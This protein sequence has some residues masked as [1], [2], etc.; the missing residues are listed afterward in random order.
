[1]KTQITMLL[2]VG[3]IVA[4]A[5]TATADTI[6]FQEGVNGYTHDA[7]TLREHDQ[8]DLNGDAWDNMYLGSYFD[9]HSR[10]LMD[11]DLSSLGAAGMIQIDSITLTVTQYTNADAS[12]NKNITYALYETTT[13]WVSSEATWNNRL[14]PDYD[15]FP[16]V[17]TAWDAG[18][19]T[20]IKTGDTYAG[21]GDY[22][23]EISNFVTN[24]TD[25]DE[26]ET[27]TW[28]STAAF[29]TAAQNAFDDD[30]H[31]ELLAA[32]TNTA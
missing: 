28:G 4:L 24:P 5:G 17:G 1:M 31:L 2:V 8:R 3:M 25:L 7:T 6:T 30:G 10:A 15:N 11:F 22:G 13:D 29:V 12:I 32:D 23:P 21:G 20:D 9:T 16:D 19:Y 27:F 18:T 14:V 26:G